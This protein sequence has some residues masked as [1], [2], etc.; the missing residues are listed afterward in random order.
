M[1]SP[2][3]DGEVD[4]LYGDNETVS[5][6]I[7]NSSAVWMG[8]WKALKIDPPSST[9]KWQLFNLTKDPGE[10]IDLSNIHPDILKTMRGAYDKF[11]KDVGIV[12]PTATRAGEMTKLSQEEASTD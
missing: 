12:I 2:L 1:S 5:Q 11:A 8:G 10:N 4:R 7:F 9:G 6:E 3:L